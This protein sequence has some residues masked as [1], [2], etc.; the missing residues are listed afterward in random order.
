MAVIFISC[1]EVFG[2]VMTFRWQH[3]WTVPGLGAKSDGRRSLDMD[4]HRAGRRETDGLMSSVAWQ[5]LG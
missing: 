1:E 4:L 3:C 2:Y 5:G